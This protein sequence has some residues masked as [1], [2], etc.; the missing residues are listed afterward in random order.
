[1]NHKL[2]EINRLLPDNHTAEISERDMREA[3]K[4]TFD[5]MREMLESLTLGG[6]NLIKNS[7]FSQGITHWG[8]DS[9]LVYNATNQSIL[10]R[11]VNTSLGIYQFFE[12]EKNTDYILTFET[13]ASFQNE[14][15]IR[16]GLEAFDFRTIGLDTSPNQWTR[17]E[18]R[19]NSGNHGGSTPF[20][21][22]GASNLVNEFY[23]RKIKL[24]KGNKPTDWTPAPEDVEAKISGL[25]QNQPDAS[26]NNA[27]NKI[28]V[29][30]ADGTLGTINRS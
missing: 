20:A 11:F 25:F 29:V 12:I 15:R 10:I 23:L 9:G 6:R 1:M 27:F 14:H 28:L 30:K 19:F 18:L 21:I 13:K 4:L 16:I 24:E 7:N 5:G 8:I 3:F 22:K 26:R 17:Y 2:Q